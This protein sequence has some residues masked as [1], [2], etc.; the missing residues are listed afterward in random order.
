MSTLSLQSPLVDDNVRLIGGNVTGRYT[1]PTNDGPARS[2]ACRAQSI[3]AY[4]IALSAP[5]AG[6][7]GQSVNLYFPE[8]GIL[9]GIISRLHDFGF[10]VDLIAG[11]VDREVIRSKIRWLRKRVSHEVVDQRKH[12]RVLPRNPES[13]LVLAD[14]TMFPCFI[15]DL[16]VSGVAASADYLPSLGEPLAIG[17]VVGRIARLFD[18]GFAVHFITAQEHPELERLLAKLESTS[19]EV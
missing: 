15:I 9:S 17:R 1:L 6:T 13:T 4:S 2:F 8:F 14:G 11:E 18:V 7:S 16:S 19:W 3:S 10:T 12:A 5:V